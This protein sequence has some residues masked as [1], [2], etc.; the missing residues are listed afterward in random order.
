MVGLTAVLVVCGMAVGGLAIAGWVVNVA[1]SAP[2]L[3]SIHPTVPGSPSQVFAADGQSLGYIWSPTVHTPVP[4]TEIPTIVKQATVAI[5]DRRF[6]HH[7]ALDYQG[8]VRAAIKD[9]VSGH[10]LQGAS[11]LTMQLVDNDYLPR[12]YQSAR[13]QHDLK[14]KIVQAKLAEQLEGEHS[15]TWILDSY[16]NDVPYGT[17]RDQTAYGVGAASEMFFDKPV[18]KLTLDQAALLAGLPQ[19]PSEYNPFNDRSAA[20]ARRAEVLQAMVTAGDISQAQADAASS[21]PLEVKPDDAY[22]VKRDPYVFEFIEQALSQDLCP[23]T[24]NHCPRLTQGGMKVYTTIDLRKEALAHQ[25]ILDHEATLAEQGPSSWGSAAAGLASI[26][27]NNGHILAIASSSAYSKTNFDYATQ[28][29][30]QPGSAFKTFALMTLIH[31]YHADPNDTYYT[32]KF[33]PAGWLPADPTWSVHTAEESYQGTISVTKATTVSDNTVYAQMAADLGY[34]KLDDTAHAMGVTSPLDGYPSEVIG[35]LRVGVTPLEMADAYGTLA[36]GGTHIPA[37]IIGKV[38]FPDGS[39]DNF[40]NPKRTTVF[41]Y[42]QAYEGTQVLKTVVTSGTG[43]NANYGCPAAGKTGTANDLDNAWFVGYTP[44][45][46]TAVWVGYP[47][48]NLPMYDG[49]G[50]DLAAPIWRSYM[51]PASSG[52]CG[53][54]TPPTVPFEGTSFVG[55]HSATTPVA[56]PKTGTGSGAGTGGGPG[57]GKPYNNKTLFAQPPQTAPGTGQTGTGQT[58]GGTGGNG[59]GGGHHGGSTGG[60]GVSH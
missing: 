32:S 53:D 28:A 29:H 51:E 7:G 15:K 10:S 31:D 52:Y 57:T 22:S 25:A 45:M 42:N 30:R 50:G 55:P 33:L 58:G 46:A 37:T 18:Q 17:V 1:H 44:R 27:P 23:R 19:A 49:F 20:R 41:P 47:Q 6:Y 8:I 9:A 36:N 12:A 13:Q 54:W 2:N 48:G 24:P 43:T 11:T 3:S 21:R 56:P 4:G 5:E 34:D 60:T 16:L 26:D 38:V 35:G 59:G 39:S 14:Y 40:G